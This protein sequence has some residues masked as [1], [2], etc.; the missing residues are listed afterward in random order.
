MKIIRSKSDGHI[1]INSTMSAFKHEL[2]NRVKEEERIRVD[3]SYK[4]AVLKV[5]EDCQ[6]FLPTEDFLIASVMRNTFQGGES[7]TEAEE[8]IKKHIRLNLHKKGYLQKEGYRIK[9]R[10]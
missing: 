7:Y 9:I 3:S 10:G 1:N 4:D 6:D 5:L 8:R 2:E